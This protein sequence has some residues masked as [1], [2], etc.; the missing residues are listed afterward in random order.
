MLSG[1]SRKI[2]AR[3]STTLSVDLS[4]CLYNLGDA[5]RCASDGSVSVLRLVPFTV[6]ALHAIEPWF[7]DPETCR[8]VGDRR[9]PSMIL[10]LAASPPAEH[11]GQRVLDRR[12]WI[13]KEDGTPAGV[14]DVEIYEDRSASLAFV[15]APAR[16]GR[17]VGRRALRTVVEQLE[18]GGVRQVF[19]GAEADNV[20]SIRCME[21]AG[22]TRRSDEPDR[23]GFLYF[24]RH[25]DAGRSD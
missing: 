20:A 8:W 2:R 24:A 14:V 4:H 11:R 19:G 12:A 17:G 21:S 18:G 7:D 9:W 25:L 10:R 22:F 16:R 15:I 5:Q 13:V 3:L 6:A 23:D 1:P